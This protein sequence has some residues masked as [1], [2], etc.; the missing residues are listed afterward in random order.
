MLAIALGAMQ[1]V[2]YCQLLTPFTVR[3]QVTQKGGIVFISNGA[4][5]CSTSASCTAAR[6]ETP[7]AGTSTNAGFAAAY[8]DMDTDA[9]TFQSS[10]DSLNLADCSEISWAGLYWG[11]QN[12]VGGNNYV[13]RGSCKIKFNNDAYIPLSVTPQDNITGFDSYHCFSDITDL[14]KQ[15][16]GQVRIT[17]ANV[18]VRT[19]F[20]NAFGGWTVVVIYKNRLQPMRKL[21]VYD[22]LAN[23]SGTNFNTDINVSG[24]LTP[25]SGPIGF[26]AGV[27]AYDGDRATTGDGLEF[28]GAGSF[29]SMSD[30]IHPATD[31]FNST[32]SKN[33]VL[34]PYRLPNYNNTLG[35]D[36]N[37]FN[38]NN[39]TKQYIGNS[40]TGATIRIKTTN[41]SY[42]LQ[43]ATL[44][45]DVYEPELRSTLQLTD[46]NGG[47]VQPGDTVEYRIIN[48]NTGSDAAINTYITDTL[49]PLVSFVPGS[50]KILLGPNAGDKTDAAG[51][52]QG[53]YYSSNRTVRMRIGSGAN[54]VSGGTMMNSTAGIDSTVVSFR[55]VVTDNCYLQQCNNLIAEQSTIFGTGN[56]SGNSLSARSTTNDIDVLGCIISGGTSLSIGGACTPLLI[57]SN[58]PVC[59]GNTINVA[60]PDKPGVTYLWTGPNGFSSTTANL[61]RTNATTAMAGTYSCTV[62][63]TGT[64]CS[65]VYSTVINVTPAP[66]TTI[67]YTGAYCQATSAQQLPTISGTSGGTFTATPTGL[68]INS[69]TGAIT[70]VTSLPGNYVV[71][72]TVAASGGCNLFS[73]TIAVEIV[74]AG[75]T[76]A[77]AGL[78]GGPSVTVSHD[79]AASGVYADNECNALA[80]LVA[81][82]ASPIAGNINATVWVE[83]NVPDYNGYPYVAR[84]YEISPAMNS[85]TATASITLYFLQAEFDAFNAANNSILKLPT[86]PADASGISNLRI[87]KI[88][89]SSS[90]GTGLFGS[91]TGTFTSINPDDN[92]IIYNSVRQRW[93]VSFDVIG[94]SGFFVQTINTI[95][96]ITFI[97]VSANLNAA[98]TA[99]INW[100]VVEQDI[101]SF[102]VEKSIDGITYNSIGNVISLGD[103]THQ[104]SFTE[105]AVLNG[106]AYYR[107]KEKGKNGVVSR[108]MIVRLSSTNNQQFSILPNPTHGT[109][110]IMISANLLNSK[111]NLINS[112]GQVIERFN[113]SELSFLIDM[114]KYSKGVYLLQFNDGTF[115]KIIRK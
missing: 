36:A 15:K 63:V 23:V 48:K 52:D 40:A 73:T 105:A 74:T 42:L 45:I 91:Y 30:A 46:I 109:V 110:R 39:S 98:K 24:F 47:L 115:G 96:P 77:L 95:L 5:T 113:I 100:K 79:I 66:N 34:T 10:S 53:E 87:S 85:G 28:N 29:I 93:E 103:G 60:V 78:P 75:N 43:A 2:S 8:I 76:A 108:S 64:A 12:Q 14:L 82:G 54:G 97:N 51:D 69:V 56:V 71:T 84:H 104:Y 6:T 107:I 112:A 9:S 49:S 61:T 35:Y 88:S 81:A 21:V 65:Y 17:V 83:N 32:L 3:K 44:A 92:N 4:I 99:T 18:A 89:G 86:G 26:E 11:G 31:M 16:G 72:Y 20:T 101:E 67:T 41:D 102:D 58:D 90:D 50:L 13:N 62:S 7:P 19:G 114:S 37:I 68:D 38:P 27:I 33:G 57:S 70:P 22:G 94:F 25:L 59:E 106:I 111:A 1:L 55:V 80:N